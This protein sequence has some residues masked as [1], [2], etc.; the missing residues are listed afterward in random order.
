MRPILIPDSGPLF[1][2][3]AGDLLDLLLKFRIAITDVVKEETIERGVLHGASTEAARLHQFYVS[4]VKSIQISPTQVGLGIQHLRQTSPNAP[5]PPNAGELSIQSLL[6]ELS[7]S[8]GP[9][10]IVL[11]EDGWF[12][13][14]VPALHGSCVLVSTEAFLVNAQSLG[15]IPSAEEARKA[16]S[17]LRPLA[18][19]EVKVIRKDMERKD[20]ER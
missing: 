1:S 5:L 6:I 15:L 12:L 16:I 4:N 20:M 2:L 19:R 14:N 10:P 18:Y 8:K 13:R 9:K 17:N 11:F 7:G 3:A